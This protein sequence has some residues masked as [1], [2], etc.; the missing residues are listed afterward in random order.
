[1]GAFGTL[2]NFSPISNVTATP[3]SSDK[4]GERTFH[5]SVEYVYVYSSD[6]ASVGHAVCMT[7]TTGYTVSVGTVTQFDIPVGWVQHATLTTGTYGWVATK[8][9]INMQ[10]SAA[11]SVA[12]GGLVVAGANGFMVGTNN[13]ASAATATVPGPAV[14]RAFSNVA[15]TTSGYFYVR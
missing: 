9:V 13:Y 14:A 8:G 4:L 15:S 6:A 12:I 3:G 5:N 2:V 11:V 7:G 1:M 10:M